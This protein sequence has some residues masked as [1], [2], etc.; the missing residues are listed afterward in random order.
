MKKPYSFVL[1]SINNLNLGKIAW[2]LYDKFDITSKIYKN[3]NG[4]GTIYYTLSVQSF[5]E[6]SKLI[7]FDLIDRNLL[8]NI[9]KRF[10]LKLNLNNI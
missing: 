9:D 4:F 10:I 5:K 6:I 8:K 1:F 3:I 2:Y 7:S